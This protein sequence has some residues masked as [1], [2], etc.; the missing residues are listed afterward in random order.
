MIF[1]F[2]SFP[3]SSAPPSFAQQRTYQPPTLVHIM[4]FCVI[5]VLN[6]Y[7]I[8]TIFHVFH[9]SLQSRWIFICNSFNYYLLLCFVYDTWM[10][11]VVFIEFF[12]LGSIFFLSHFMP[13]KRDILICLDV[14]DRP[15]FIR[16]SE[17]VM[18]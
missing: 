7:K 1:H 2:S 6:V 9:S 4:G 17:N 12:L 11:G 18:M 3:F 5:Y 8:H 16:Y 14:Q 13:F 15:L 10:V